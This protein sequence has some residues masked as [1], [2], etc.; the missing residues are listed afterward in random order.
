MSSFR[1]QVPLLHPDY[2]PGVPVFRID[3]PAIPSGEIYHFSTHSGLLYEVQF[4]RKRDNYFGFVINFGVLNEYFENE[5]AMT[6]ENEAFR[7]IATVI[8]IVRRFFVQHPLTEYF[9]FNGEFRE[10]E[11]N[12][13][14]SVRTRLFYRT[15]SRV[16]HPAYWNVE[17]QGN[18]VIVIRK[19]TPHG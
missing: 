11:K 4:G 7:I 1:G 14:S 9:E 18:R 8:E 12:R 10:S 3:D 5:Y 13:P 17:I 19:Q 16:V 6:H 15:A 2:Q